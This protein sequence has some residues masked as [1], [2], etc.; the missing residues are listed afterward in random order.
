MPSELDNDLRY[1]L[2]RIE[3]QLSELLQATK[4]LV[5]DLEPRI[6]G[7]ETGRASDRAYVFGGAGVVGFLAALV[8]QFL[9]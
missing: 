3:G 8:P 7:L 5:D 6:R 2:G 1:R 9:K 4:D